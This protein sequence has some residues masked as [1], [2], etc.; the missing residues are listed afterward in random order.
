MLFDALFYSFFPLFAILTHKIVSV[1]VTNEH[2]CFLHH[3][4]FF[5]IVSENSVRHINDTRI[6]EMVCKSDYGTENTIQNSLLS[7]NKM[8]INDAYGFTASA[9][10]GFSSPVFSR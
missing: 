4:S 8:Q 9:T 7:Y 5:D 3:F 10:R 6:T 2:E 1:I